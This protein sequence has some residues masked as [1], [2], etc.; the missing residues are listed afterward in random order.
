MTVT[1]NPQPYFNTQL[2]LSRRQK[3][4]LALCTE[5]DI[6]VGAPRS[7]SGSDANLYFPRLVEPSLLDPDARVAPPEI[8]P[9]RYCAVTYHEDRHYLY[10]LYATLRDAK[11]RAV[12]FIVNDTFTEMPL[13]VVDLQ[14][15]KRWDAAITATWKSARQ[16]AVRA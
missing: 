14:T 4:L 9:A 6:V 3:A 10:P 5:Y 1:R 11:A 2:E 13:C 12:E 16:L 15:G 8:N 7:A